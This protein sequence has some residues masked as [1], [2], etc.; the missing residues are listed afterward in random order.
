MSSTTKAVIITLVIV[1]VLNI[2]AF[3]ALRSQGLQLAVVASDA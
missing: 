2:A 3:A 1:A